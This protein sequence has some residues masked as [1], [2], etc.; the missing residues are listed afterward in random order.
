MKKRLSN[1]FRSLGYDTGLVIF[2]V[3]FSILWIGVF[4]KIGVKV[5]NA[6]E[7][8]TAEDYKWL[9]EQEEVLQEDFEKVYEMEGAQIEVQNSEII[10]TLVSEQNSDYE[11]RITFNQNKQKV[12][13][14]EICNKEG[15]RNTTLI[16]PK[17]EKYIPKA[18]CALLGIMLGVA[19]AVAMTFIYRF[20]YQMIINLYHIISKIKQ[21]KK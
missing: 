16:Y 1:F 2:G 4:N 18:E 14:E 21:K 17:M 20:F 12:K 8:P 3:L 5:F 13:A 15:Y 10:V 11:L 7:A 6:F 19:S 9:H